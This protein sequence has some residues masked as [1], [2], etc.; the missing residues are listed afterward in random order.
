MFCS[1]RHSFV[2]CCWPLI[3]TFSA[4]RKKNILTPNCKDEHSV[5]FCWTRLLNPFW[6][7]FFPPGIG[8]KGKM[9]FTVMLLIFSH[10]YSRCGLLQICKTHRYK[11]QLSQS[12]LVIA[13][14]VSIYD[15]FSN[16]FLEGKKKKE[17]Q[18]VKS[19]LTDYMGSC[20][21]SPAHCAVNDI[22]VV[23][24]IRL[25]LPAGDTVDEHVCLLWKVFWQKRLTGAKKRI[26]V[27]HVF[28]FLLAWK[29][30]VA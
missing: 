30:T 23:I 12:V 5:R 6:P 17:S 20:G 25:W 16:W 1:S 10:V 3:Y 18:W 26:H 24:M 11:N 7:L 29:V 21:A 4:D 28:G 22:I 27:S 2:F 8:V 9:C 19:L 15:R 13:S 14:A